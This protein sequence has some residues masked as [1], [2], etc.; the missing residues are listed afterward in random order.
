M[1]ETK[2]TNNQKESL[3]SF[4]KMNKYY[5]F[6]FLV[7]IVCWSTKFCTDKMKLGPE[8]EK[9][10]ENGINQDI[11]HTFVFVYLFINSTSHIFGGLLYFIS[12][13]KTKTKKS[14]LKEDLIKK[15]EKNNS[16]KNEKKI[17]N[18]YDTI[19]L[20]EK[21]DKYKE[22]EISLIIFGMALIL[23]IYNTIKGYAISYPQ[24]EKRLYFLFF[25]TIFNI[26]V[27]KK[28]I[29]MH[30]K[31]SLGIAAL[32]MGI[33]FGI[34]FK[35]LN[36]GRY[37]VIYDILLFFGSLFYSLYLV[38]VKYLTL[39][40]G[41][42]PFLVI[43]L[44][45]LFSTLFTIAGFLL[46]SLINKGDL[47][48]ILN[49]FHCSDINYL[50]LENYYLEIIFYFIINS[51]LQVLI[52]LVIYYFS[53]EVFAISDILSPMLSFITKSI[54]QKIRSGEVDLLNIALNTLGYI[55][56]LL[57]SLIYN[58][59]IVCNFCGL[60]KNTWNAIGLRGNDELNKRNYSCDSNSVDSYIIDRDSNAKD[61]SF[62]EIANESTHKEINNSNI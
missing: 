3:F 11:E 41:M 20:K 59:I 61:D 32:G 33:L 53:P 4:T 17:N 36:F 34:Y 43:L 47:F 21:K 48:Y 13:L 57:G 2:N 18:I 1:S 19:K 8:P 42:S 37:N 9:V 23:T 38:L 56:I 50:C 29:F 40:H 31:L 24:L 10:I 46:F 28:Q 16:I 58:E 52:F 55:I 25:I 51:V 6:P 39:N 44:I 49:I 15:I 22:L 45:G 12:I 60:N 54:Y 35:Y 27:L 62:I 14:K 26:Y 7:P 5:L 30:Q